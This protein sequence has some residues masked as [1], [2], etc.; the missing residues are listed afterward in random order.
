MSYY[1]QDPKKMQELTI[2][3]LQNYF[4]SRNQEL[5]SLP[6]QKPASKK[7]QLNPS[8]LKINSREDFFKNGQDRQDS[9][10]EFLKNIDLNLQ[11]GDEFSSNSSKVN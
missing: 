7:S 2:I 5:W 1:T 10:E 3:S 4:F 8:R 11:D 9:E 6:F